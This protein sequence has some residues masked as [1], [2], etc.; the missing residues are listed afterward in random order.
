MAAFTVFG[1]D[2][3]ALLEAYARWTRAVFFCFC[4]H[5]TKI[6]ARLTRNSR[7]FCAKRQIIP[8]YKNIVDI[9]SKICYNVNNG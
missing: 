2:C 4:T 5:C 7:K 9:T 3:F 8:Q 1:K 6:P